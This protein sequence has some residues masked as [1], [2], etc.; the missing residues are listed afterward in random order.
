MKPF[1]YLSVDNA[2]EYSRRKMACK[3]TD[4]GFARD[5]AAWAK[6]AWKGGGG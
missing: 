5:G 1:K 6:S 2:V 4:Q 3:N